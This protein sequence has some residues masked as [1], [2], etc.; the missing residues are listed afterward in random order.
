MRASEV[1]S[2][3]GTVAAG[4]RCLTTS[5]SVRRE[6]AGRATEGR[7]RRA[8]AGQEAT[9]EQQQEQQGAQERP[10]LGEERAALDTLPTS[11]SIST[12]HMYVLPHGITSVESLWRHRHNPYQYR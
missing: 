6:E 2:K 11:L 5:D 7:C 8:S 3:V 10:T 12:F 4:M 9:F 1:S